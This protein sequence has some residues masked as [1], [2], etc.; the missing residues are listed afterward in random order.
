LNE[1]F[2]GMICG[3]LFR[4]EYRDLAG[5]WRRRI[6]DNR[7]IFSIQGGLKPDRW[8]EFSICW[9]LAGGLP[10]TPFAIT[11]SEAMRAGIYDAERINAG[12]L[13]PYHS[14]SLRA[15]RRFYFRKTNLIVYLSLWNVYNRK[16]VASYYWNEIEN[17]P[18]Y[19]F[20]FGFLPVMGIE[21]E[22]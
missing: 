13:P 8:W 3:S 21:F 6:Y 22:F 19:T 4:C 10:Y 15:D 1:K 9:T 12:R 17:R 20:Q 18:G 11:A 16:N 5:T 2:Y 7:Y 14:L